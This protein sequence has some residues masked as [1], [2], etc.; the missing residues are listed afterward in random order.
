MNKKLIIIALC[1][2]LSGCASLISRTPKVVLLP[3][4]RI[5][6]VKQG[7]EITVYLDHKEMSMTFPEDM[8]LVST[9][10]LVRQE[11]KLNNA[12]LDKIKADSG[13]KKFL[14]IF[15]S[16]LGILAFGLGIFFKM[17]KWTPNIKMEVK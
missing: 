7:Q 3:E 12:L 4:E 5:F 16:I 17:K 9:T 10:V 8:K 11:E 6:T 2:T 13:K 1:L 15:G 14:M